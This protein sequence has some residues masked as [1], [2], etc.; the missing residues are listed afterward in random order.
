VYAVCALVIVAAEMRQ[1][2]DLSVYGTRNA[3]NDLAYAVFYKCSIYN[4]LVMPLFSFLSPRMHFARV[5][6][7]LPLPPF[8]SVI[9]YWIVMDFLNYWT[10]RLLHAVPALWAFH[11]VHHTQT[12]LTFLSANRIHV[13]EQ[14]LS[15]VLMIVP[16]FLLGVPQRLWLPLLLVQLFSETLQH[17]RL[18]WS[19]GAMHGLLVSPVFHK[20][21]HSTDER[22][23]NGNYGRVLSLWDAMFGSFVHSSTTERH[24]GVS[25]MDVPETLTAQFLH[26]FRYLL[27]R[28]S[29]QMARGENLAPR[30][31]NG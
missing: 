16:A 30:V 5:G 25:G 14:L 10:H 9:V 6:L 21:H 8:L 13:V 1:R 2:D 11:S 31:L 15:G 23:Y 12:K 27:S 7:L 18:N 22:E 29:P 17:A 20:I 19:F 24:Y 4:I 26:P 28:R 3:L